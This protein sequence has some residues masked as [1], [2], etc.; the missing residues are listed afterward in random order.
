MGAFLQGYEPLIILLILLL[1]L[2]PSKLP[3]LARGLGQAVREFRKASQ[4][5]YD[6]EPAAPAVKASR[7]SSEDDELL[8]SLARKLG[9]STEGKTR[10]QIKREVIERAKEKGLA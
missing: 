5:L 3:A 7:G 9:V 10:E 6:E 1:V 2:G 8:Y 4:G